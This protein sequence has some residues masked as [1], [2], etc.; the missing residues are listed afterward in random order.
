MMTIRMFV[1]LMIVLMLQMIPRI[2]TTIWFAGTGTNKAEWATLPGVT[3][4]L[5][6]DL[7]VESIPRSMSL[8]TTRHL[9]LSFSLSPRPS[10]HATPFLSCLYDLNVPGSRVAPRRPAGGVNPSIPV[11]FGLLSLSRAR[12][13]SRPLSLSRAPDPFSHSSTLSL[14]L[15]DLHVRGVTESLLVDLQVESIPGSPILSLLY[16]S[17]SSSFCLSV[18]LRSCPPG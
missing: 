5:L 3:E 11:A 14:Y 17:V 6:V 1:I 8:L 16:L 18:S 9:S 15:Y 12:A 13:L 7:Q 4:S 2:P 10:S